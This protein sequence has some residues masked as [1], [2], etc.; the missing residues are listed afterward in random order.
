MTEETRE[1]IVKAT[2]DLARERGFEDITVRAIA[3]RA[4]VALSAMN[5]HFGGKAEAI[6]EAFA[7]VS[8]DLR[9]CFDE[10]G[11]TAQ[12]DPKGSLRNFGERFSRVVRK[13]GAALAYFAAGNGKGFARASAYRTF[14]LGEGVDT[15]WG[16][17]HAVDPAITRED[18]SMRL[19][20]LA[21]AALYPELVS[22]A[23]GLDWENEGTAEAYARLLGESLVPGATGRDET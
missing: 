3:E 14:S 16:A 1:A 12:E 4:G 22:G 13:N 10:L 21:G 8:A 9:A 23:L 18:A 20:Q 19:C 17:M 6:A 7:F 5:Y 11:G 15:V 2:L